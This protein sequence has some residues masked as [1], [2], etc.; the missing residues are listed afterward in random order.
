MFHTVE[1]IGRFVTGMPSR[2][3]PSLIRDSTCQQECIRSHLAVDEVP[4]ILF[5]ASDL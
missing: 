1:R 4:I 3:H 5:D 2:R